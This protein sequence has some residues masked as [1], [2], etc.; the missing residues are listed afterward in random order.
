MRA[1]YR[2]ARALGVAAVLVLA[3]CQGGKTDRMANE[4]IEVFQSQP[5]RAFIQAVLDKRVADAMRLASPLPDGVN[6]VS[7]SGETALLYAVQ[8]NDVPMV[9]ALLK[10]GADPN[11]G[12]DRAPLHPATR[13][14]SGRLL[15]ILLRAGA[16]PA[17]TYN[18]ET[19]L[20]EAALIDERGNAA[21]LIAAKAPLDKGNGNNLS[22]AMIAASAGH[23]IM[24]TQLIDA[25]ASPW[26]TPANGQTLANLAAFDRLRPE[27][28]EGQARDRII[29]KFRGFGYP[30]PPPKPPEVR[31]LVAAGR[32]PPKMGQPH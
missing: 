2:A 26:H 17:R 7:P 32:W 5:E 9:E 20:W 1:V 25:G 12:P 30:W 8:A 10:A 11:G 23:W 24:A 21:K 4:R 6:T 13:D 3:A 29:E 15:T 16:D 19:P 31:A 28:E 18:T 22:P 27:T 14:P